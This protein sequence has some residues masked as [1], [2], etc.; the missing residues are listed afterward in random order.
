MNFKKQLESIKEKIKNLSIEKK[1]F[2]KIIAVS[3]TVDIDTIKEAY[4]AGQ[5]VFGENRMEQLNEKVPAL[6]KDIEWHMIGHLQSNKTKNMVELVDWIDSVDSLKLI[7][8]IDKV[9]SKL[10][11]KINILI[12]INVSG[13]EAKYGISP[14]KIEELLKTAFDKENII[15]HGFMTMAPFSASDEE[16]HKIFASLG[17]LRDEMEDILNVKLPELSMGMSGDYE[18]AVQEGA[19]QVRIGSALFR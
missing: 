3:K 15:C 4:D 9:A 1:S 13:E 6:P 5:R 17:V 19:S 10:N 7:N 12:Q 16:L 2:P 14:E 18:I 11:K 8:K